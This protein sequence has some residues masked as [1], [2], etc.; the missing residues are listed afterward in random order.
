MACLCSVELFCMEHRLHMEH[1]VMTDSKFASGSY[2]GFFHNRDG[3]IDC[4]NKSSQTESL[5]V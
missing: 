2:I 5:F 4:T 3:Q 1:L